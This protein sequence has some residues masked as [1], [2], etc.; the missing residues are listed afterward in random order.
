MKYTWEWPKPLLN[1]LKKKP[2]EKTDA[3]KEKV[4]FGE[5]LEN[6]IEV[7]MI[8]LLDG[9]RSEFWKSTEGPFSS[10]FTI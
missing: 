10:I 2:T 7:N 5:D 8:S 4:K 3:I 1:K 6:R 9:I